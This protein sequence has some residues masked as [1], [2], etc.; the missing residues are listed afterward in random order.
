MYVVETKLPDGRPGYL[1]PGPAGGAPSYALDLHKAARF[2]TSREAAAASRAIPPALDPT[3]V[4]LGE[5][6]A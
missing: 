6:S 3:V 2:N 4:K 1:A 5:G